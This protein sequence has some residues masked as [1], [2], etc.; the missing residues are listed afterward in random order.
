M[1]N[2]FTDRAR[3]QVKFSSLFSFYRRPY[4]FPH[5]VPRTPLPVLVTSVSVTANAFFCQSKRECKP[6]DNQNVECCF[7]AR[8]WVDTLTLTLT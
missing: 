1:R 6:N 4:F 2:E 7:R 5:P 3:V 8:V